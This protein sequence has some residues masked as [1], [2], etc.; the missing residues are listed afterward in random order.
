MVNIKKD[1]HLNVDDVIINPVYANQN[2]KF[3]ESSRQEIIGLIIDDFW[4]QLPYGYT[5]YD[6]W[7]KQPPT[8]VG[9]I[10]KNS[11]HKYGTI[12]LKLKDKNKKY[13]YLEQ[14]MRYL[15]YDSLVLTNKFAQEL[16]VKG[17]EKIYGVREENSLR[18]LVEC[19]GENSIIFGKDLYPTILRK[20]AHLWYMLARYQYF[21]NG[22][23]RTGILAALTLLEINC[24]HVKI[25]SD[26]YALSV[27]VANKKINEEDLY[28]QLYQMIELNKVEMKRRIKE[29]PKESLKD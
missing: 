4:R 17:E 20:A 24:F 16:F 28:R 2:D 5:H 9:G 29:L 23:K 27:G 11:G 12:T 19:A 18:Y 13:L 26:L 7:K 3:K 1:L 8:Y 14:P 21:A 25:S 6:D 22:N 15:T 10:D